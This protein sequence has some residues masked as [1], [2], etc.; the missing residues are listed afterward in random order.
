MGGVFFFF[1]GGVMYVG[2]GLDSDGFFIVEDS[3]LG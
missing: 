2:V 3:F 1:F